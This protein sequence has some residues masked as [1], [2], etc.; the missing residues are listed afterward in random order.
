MRSRTLWVVFVCMLIGVAGC[1]SNAT[2]C[3]LA[4]NTSRPTVTVGDVKLATDHS[5]YAVGEPIAVSVTN[6]SYALIQ[7]HRGLP[8]CPYV[9][10]Q[11][12]ENGTW[13]NVPVC[14]PHPPSGDTEDA[15][16]PPLV[17]KSGLTYRTKVN[18]DT[19]PAGTYRIVLSY[20]VS[21]FSDTESYTTV[22]SNT[23]QVCTCGKCG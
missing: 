3:I 21:P 9:L 22:Y 23:I 11:R 6:D 18:T 8:Y 15:S 20:Q 13:Q 10:L 19:A 17:L 14:G 2:D 12:Q 7:T 5:V 4:T 16:F 1:G